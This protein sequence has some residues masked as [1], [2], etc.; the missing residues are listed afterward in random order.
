MA[1]SKLAVYGAMGANVAIAVTKFIAAAI[2]GSSSML[3][4][5]IHS[6]VDTGNSCLLLIGLNRSRRPPTREHPYGHGKELYFWTLIVGV[7]IFGVGGG[8]SFYEGILHLRHPPPLEDPLWNY[9]VLA[10]AAVFE[11][12]SFSLGWK[13]FNAERKG[14]PVLQALQT[15]KDPATLTVMAEDS[16]ALVGLALAACGVF[17]SHWLQRPE[18]D[19]IASMAIGELLAGVAVVLIA[20]SRDLLIGE[21]VSVATARELRDMALQDGFTQVGPILSMFMGPHE[22]LVTLSVQ[23]DPARASGEVA[24]AVQGLEA[25][26]RERWPV[27]KRVYIEVSPPDEPTTS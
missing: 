1:E 13:Q 26:V 18:L 16:A 8:V 10:C 5:G 23:A 2:T 14:R 6:M 4:E 7:L 25:R 21:G 15:S 27:I 9:A 19:A 20:A 24:A 12:I 3:S 17:F 22:A 11:S